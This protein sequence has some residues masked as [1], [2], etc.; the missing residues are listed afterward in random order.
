MQE[1]LAEARR[2][3]IRIYATGAPYACKEALRENGYRWSSGE[4]GCER[5]W[6]KDVEKGA[7]LASER[8]CLTEILGP[9][10]TPNC[11]WITAWN[12]FVP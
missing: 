10:Q 12:R 7:L 2:E 5:A 11:L 1:L 8:A 6:F 3:T 9:L 4:D